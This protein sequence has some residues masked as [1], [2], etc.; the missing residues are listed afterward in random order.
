MVY[1][2]LTPIVPWLPAPS[3]V[4]ESVAGWPQVA[5][6]VDELAAGL[7][8]PVVLAIP[9]N[10][11][12]GAAQLTYHTRGRYP[13]TIM[14]EPLKHSVWPAP[15]EFPNASVIW[16][17]ASG[18]R[19]PPPETYF[20]DPSERGAVPVVVRGQEIRRFHFWTAQGFK[21]PIGK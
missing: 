1:A 16:I 21:R 7:P 18:W 14:P 13:V 12:E 6:R 3:P 9:I 8:A 10:H 11:F 2:T 5:R 4:L 19:V 15:E 20:R 17:V